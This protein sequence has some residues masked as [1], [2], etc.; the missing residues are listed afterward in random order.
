MDLLTTYSNELLALVAIIIVIFIYIQIK[1]NNSKKPTPLQ[2]ITPKENIETTQ[3]EIPLESPKI[4]EEDS[5][6]F[7]IPEGTE[8]G[9]FEAEKQVEESHSTPQTNF[10]K[11]DV[12]PH[13]KISKENFTQFAGERILVAE[14][15]L[16]NQKVILGLL[17][18]SGVE[19]IIANDGIEVLEK[20]K[21][22]KEFA[23]IL[24]DAHMPRMDGFEATR[25]IRQNPEYDHIAVI[26]L[27]GDTATDDIQKMLNAGMS[28]HLEKPLKVDAL[29]DIFY[30]YTS[31][32]K[33][34]SNFKELNIEEGLEIC[35]NDKEFYREILSE[36]L[37]SYKD[38]Y[39]K[40]QNYLKEKDL[41]SA[42]K[43][44]LDI[45]GVAANIG[46][47]N[48]HSSATQLKLALQ[49]DDN[50]KARSLFVF[51]ENLNNLLKEIK[52]YLTE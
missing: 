28:E 13:G 38:S 51:K 39:E 42:D 3:E 11:R 15:N 9:T 50:E 17:A 12:P 31:G 23:F 8:E 20:L 52:R 27:S 22:D 37:H 26:A 14:D 36:F 40:I 10:R 47:K 19:I 21:D 45:L 25:K 32:K 6:L 43:L 5:E 30:A 7:H 35:G 34:K 46:A 18:Q 1:K 41:S 44:L 24:M 33:D 2:T 48:L 4:Q 16:I 29:Y 49:S